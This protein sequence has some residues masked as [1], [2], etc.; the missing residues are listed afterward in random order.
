MHASILMKISIDKSWKSFNMGNKVCIPPCNKLVRR[1]LE[2][3]ALS[4]KYAT[5]RWNLQPPEDICNQ[6]SPIFQS[7]SLGKSLNN[8]NGFQ[9]RH[10]YHSKKNQHV[11]HARGWSAPLW[12][13]D[14]I[15]VFFP[16]KKSI[17]NPFK[18]KKQP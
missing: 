18:M 8:D 1:H 14:V 12:K 5:M 10:V 7:A 2:W 11:N 13:I 6:A 17:M 4:G 16:V 9:W 15:D 3:V